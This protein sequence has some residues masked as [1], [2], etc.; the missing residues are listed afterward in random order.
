M[1]DIKNFKQTKV[2]NTNEFMYIRPKEATIEA[3]ALGKK[4][5]LSK[6]NIMYIFTR[7]DSGVNGMISK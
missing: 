4:K 7:L 3:S 6:G 5:H 1:E 2:S